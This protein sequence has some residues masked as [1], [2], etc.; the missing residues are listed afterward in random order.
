MEDNHLVEAKAEHETALDLTGPRGGRLIS[1]RR[2][3]GERLPPPRSAGS[4]QEL[5]RRVPLRSLTRELSVRMRDDDEAD[6]AES[7]ELFS[8]FMR[9]WDRRM[10]NKLSI[11]EPENRHADRH[12]NQPGLPTE[13]VLGTPEVRVVSNQRQWSASRFFLL[14]N[15]SSTA[16]RPVYCSAFTRLCK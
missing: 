16:T 1:E 10:E 5:S 2:V 4:G 13:L 8:K 12:R 3:K 14:P 7:V 15:R 11:G 6:R 9:D